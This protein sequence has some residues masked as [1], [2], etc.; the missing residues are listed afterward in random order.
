MTVAYVVSRFPVLTETFVLHEIEA[1]RALGWRIELFA[2]RRERA[3]VT[4]AGARGMESR[5]YFAN[6]PLALAA[7]ARL[8]AQRPRQWLELLRMTVGG[9][10]CSPSVLARTLLVLPV[11]VGWAEQMRRLGVRHVH[12]HFGSYPAY[13]ALVAA[14]LQG[15]GFSFTVHAHDLFADNIM[16]AQKGRLAEFVVTV[17]EFNRQLLAP[18]LGPDDAGR[19]RVI[20]CGVDTRA[21][22]FRRCQSNAP[23]HALLCVAALREYKGLHHLVE[24]CRLLQTSAPDQHFVCRI[25]GDGPQRSALESQ[26]RLAGLGGSVQ[27]VGA[28]TETEI[29]RLL[30]MSDTF[31]LP[32]VVARNGYM[33][34]IPVALMEAMASGIPVIASRLSGIPEL[35]HDGETGLLVP[36]GDPPAIHNAVLRCWHDPTSSLERAVRGRALVER[37]FNLMTNASHL[38]AAFAQT[39]TPAPA[40]SSVG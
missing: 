32:S 37:E 3:L 29:R 9:T 22:Q 40:Q 18:L 6:A 2:I 1:L 8:L 33:D 36:P 28:R 17:S 16:L 14:Q 15:I 25:V 30:A 39:L 10:R 27:L 12:A 34:A 38:A 5:V 4:H 19:V 23:Q 13:A 11:A 24:A 20:H 35:V 26:I 31:V 21:F 7:N